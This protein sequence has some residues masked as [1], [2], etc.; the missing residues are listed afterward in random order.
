MTKTQSL[1][2]IVSQD[3]RIPYANS[4]IN[5][6]LAKNAVQ[7]NN[8]ATICQALECPR[9][10][11]SIKEFLNSQDDYREFQ[12]H[13]TSLGEY[14][15]QLNRLQ[16]DNNEV[17]ITVYG[18]STVTTDHQTLLS[19][20]ENLQAVI[21]NVPQNL[22]W[23]DRNSVYLGCN[24]Q[25]AKSAGRNSSREIIGL[26]DYDLP[27]DIK[28]SEA[29]IADDQFVMSSGQPR[30]NIEETQTVNDKQIILLTS[31]VPLRDSKG[32]VTGV[33]GV[34]TDITERKNAEHELELAKE[35]AEAANEAKSNFLAVMSHELRT[36]LNGILGLIQILTQNPNSAHS[37]EYI[38]DIEYAAKHLLNLV[39]DILDFS[40]LEGHIG[41]I[42]QGV[43]K[44]ENVCKEVFS[45]CQTRALAKNLKMILQYNKNIPE[46]ILGDALRLKQV[47]LNLIDNAI[48]Y[49]PQGKIEVSLAFENNQLMF[50]IKDTGI[51]IPGYMQNAVFDKFV[52][53]ESGRIR[54]FEGI[55]LGLAICKKIIEKMDGT[56][57]YD[58]TLGEGSTFWFTIPTS[59]TYDVKSEN[60]SV[61]EISVNEQFAANILVVEDNLLNQKVAR[62]LLQQLGCH[63]EV[64][65]NGFDA[66]KRANESTFNIIF[67]DI[68]LP[69][70]D[71]YEVTRKIRE[72]DANIPVIGLTAHAD[73]ADIQNCYEAKMN[74]VLIKPVTNNDFRRILSKFQS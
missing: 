48:K 20:L 14:L 72:H 71:G 35:K 26:T 49:T 45:V 63:V 6:L 55:G 57:G 15:W 56:I 61:N 44:I 8:L 32:N 21:N 64:V 38:Q 51:G 42:N 34:Y 60:T 33:I 2:F 29:Y 23:K 68:G 24:D 73:S 25:F 40:K 31:K 37:H 65:S 54:N 9:L 4:T 18:K 10:S 70:I 67:M 3:L 7:D 1:L 30:L 11:S 41:S 59:A 74:D 53:V 13:S 19:K 22:L 47:M 52:Q 12:L 39:N 50:K 69:D 28:E 43:I 5:K 17:Q 66:I 27:W 46:Y 16:S 36:P 62:L 58:S